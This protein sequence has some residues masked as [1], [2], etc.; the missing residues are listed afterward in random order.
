M[1][2]AAGTT[3]WY[4]RKTLYCMSGSPRNEQTLATSLILQI[5]RKIDRYL[6]DDTI[7]LLARKRITEITE[8]QFERAF[9]IL[10]FRQTETHLFVHVVAIGFDMTTLGHAPLIMKVFRGKIFLNERFAMKGQTQYSTTA[11]NAT[12]LPL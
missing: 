7:P 6:V 8:H 3:L 1:I 12:A 2:R 4:L 10:Q 5:I 9:N 11:L